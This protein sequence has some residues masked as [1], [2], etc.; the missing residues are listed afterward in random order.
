MIN[1]KATREDHETIIA[2]VRRARSM[3]GCVDALELNMDITAAHLN[4]CPLKL[5]EL[6]SAPDFDFA[7]DVFGIQRHI[8]RRTGKLGNFFLPRYAQPE[9]EVSHA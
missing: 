8:D 5:K 7:H 1:W 9:S 6:L 3:P 2:I 4:G